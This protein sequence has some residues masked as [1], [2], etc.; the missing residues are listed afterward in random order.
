MLLGTVR[1]DSDFCLQAE[2]HRSM[3]LL[4]RMDGPMLLVYLCLPIFHL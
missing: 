3:T 4:R 2:R 1:G